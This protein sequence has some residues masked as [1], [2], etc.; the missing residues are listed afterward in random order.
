MKLDEKLSDKDYFLKI[1][2]MSKIVIFELFKIFQV[3]GLS[4][5]LLQLHL[6][7]P[8]RHVFAEPGHGSL[9]QPVQIVEKDL[10]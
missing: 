1:I 3:V 9:L 7:H 8:G 6:E 10:I 4:R 2:S 5:R